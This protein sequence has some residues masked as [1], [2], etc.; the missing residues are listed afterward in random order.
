MEDRMKRLLLAGAGLIALLGGSSNAADLAPVYAPLPP[1]VPVF[2]WTGCY[3]GGNGGGISANSDWSDTILGDFGSNTSSGALGGAQAGCDYQASGA[4]YW[5]G[6][7]V[8]GIQGDYDWTSI[9]GSVANGIPLA[10]AVGLADQ[11]QIKSLA[12]ITGRVGGAWD[13][14][15][16]YVKAGGAWLQGNYGFR[17]FG[18]PVAPTVSLTQTGY[19]VGVG[20]EYAFLNWLTGFVEYDYYHFGDNTSSTL[21]C[22][23]AVC[24][25]AT[26]GV[27]V[28]TDINVVKAGLNLKFGP[29]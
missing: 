26:T 20:G 8:V 21:V 4:N 25:I 10:V 23:A 18:A 7:L 12:S 6:G 1:L 5:A 28:R 29:F 22:T 27:S 16:A 2:T 11:T 9:N 3:V 24:G 15:L 17:T 14:F 19:T 13:R